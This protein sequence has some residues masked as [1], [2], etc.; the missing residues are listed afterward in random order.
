MLALALSFVLKGAQYLYF[1]KFTP[2]VTCRPPLALSLIVI[3]ER[4][5]NNKE[6]FLFKFS[7]GCLKN[8]T[9]SFNKMC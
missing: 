7:V 2:I 5:V 4:S 3:I 6:Y 9:M 8:F 1:S